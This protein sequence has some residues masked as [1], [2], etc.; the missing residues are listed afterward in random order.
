MAN[1]KPARGAKPQPAAKPAAPSALD[2]TK[3]ATVVQ[4]IWKGVANFFTGKAQAEAVVRHEFSQLI[5]DIHSFYLQYHQG[6]L[7]KKEAQLLITQRRNQIPAILAFRTQLQSDLA[8]KA[9]N[10]AIITIQDAISTVLSA[11]FSGFKFAL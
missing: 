8:Q 9:T 1:S 3:E 2:P 11:A 5:E 10:D 7:T 4:D 6:S